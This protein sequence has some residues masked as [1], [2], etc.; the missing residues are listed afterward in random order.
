MARIDPVPSSEL[1]PHF[2]KLVEEDEAAG[3]DP[4]LNGV[5]GHLPELMKS[6]FEFYYP[7]HEQGT[8]ETRVKELAR[9]RIASLNECQ[10]C[11]MARYAS[12][13]RQGL[14]EEQIAQVDCAPDDRELSGRERLAVEFAEQMAIDHLA[15]DD[16]FVARLREHFSDA[17]IVELG[18]MI[19]QYIGF[20]RLLVALGIEKYSQETYTPGLG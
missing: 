5:L 12:A 16:A 17:Q 20:G 8:L 1:D 6:Y 7:A 4:A 14:T 2:R 15:I 10:T 9:L 13:Q 11:G 18:M 3:R 19:G